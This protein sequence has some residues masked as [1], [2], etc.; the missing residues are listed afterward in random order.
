MLGAFFLSFQYFIRALCLACCPL[1]LHSGP[2][3]IGGGRNMSSDSLSGVHENV[4]NSP[5]AIS[6]ALNLHLLNKS[7]S[8]TSQALLT[9]ARWFPVAEKLSLAAARRVSPTF[10]TSIVYKGRTVDRRP[11]FGPLHKPHNSLG[12][13]DNV[14]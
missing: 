1:F 8:G 7:C 6:I 3:S 10:M 5:G 2:Q 12:H 4:R 11:I 14:C 13:G 9:C